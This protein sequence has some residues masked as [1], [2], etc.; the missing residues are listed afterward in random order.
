MRRP[1][2]IVLMLLMLT[3]SASA[4][5]VLDRILAIVNNTPILLSDWDEAWRCEALLAG[6]TPE[7]YSEA[8]RQEVFQRLV[9]QEL[10]RQQMRTF[11]LTPVPPEDLQQEL[12]EVRSQLSGGNA[13]QWQS[14]LQNAGI[15]EEELA[16][17]LRHQIEVERFVDVRFRPGVRV[18]DRSIAQ[19]Y[20]GEFLPELRK[21][22]GK[23][24]PLEQVS[25]KIREILVQQQVNS[26]LNAWVQTLREQADIQ[27]PADASSAVAGGSTDSK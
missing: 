10:L 5:E 25:G 14:L 13:A 16:H 27:I 26:E 18:T 8:E 20:Q 24:V 19:Y 21:A 12:K 4:G 2:V 9:D 23:D 17:R 1:S 22:G 3:L 15:T 6:R 11:L 7:S